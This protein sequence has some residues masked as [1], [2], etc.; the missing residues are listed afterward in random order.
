MLGGEC[1]L[2]DCS[3]QQDPQPK[4]PLIRALSGF[5]VRRNVLSVSDVVLET[6]VLVSRRLE[7]K[8]I[9]S[10][11]WSWQK[12][13]WEFSRLLWVWLIAGTKN[14]NLGR[15]WVLVL[16]S[17]VL[18]ELVYIRPTV[19]IMRPSSIGGGRI[20]RRTLSVRLSVCLP[21]RPVIVAIGYVFSAP[22]ASR[23]AT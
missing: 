6:K 9:K 15:D 11:S 2:E 3:I 19:F 4:M 10:W 16:F 13:S 14:C 17:T 8:K 22:L 1:S 23:R 12:K 18:S 21:V 20:L 5:S 7:D